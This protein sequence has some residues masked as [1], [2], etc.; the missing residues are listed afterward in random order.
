MP[1][2]APVKGSGEDFKRVPPGTH[3][4]VCR[5]I[6]D[7]GMQP[8]R[9]IYPQPK[10]EIYVGFEIPGERVSYN[11]DGKDVEGP[12]SIGRTYTLSMSEKANLRKDLQ[13]WRGK[14]F[15]DEEAE[16]FDIESVA[17]KACMLTVV[18]K[19]SGEKT[20]SNIVGVSGLPKGV[21]TPK[22]ENPVIVY[23]ED[24]TR[25]F[26]KLPKWLQEKVNGQLAAAPS[27]SRN[28]V[29]DEMADQYRGA[30]DDPFDSE[31]IPF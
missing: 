12:M 21:P 25:S 18:E 13:A 27:Q 23:T 2:R 7:L 14:N 5:L 10:H 31:S 20:Y 26:D 19:V 3:I 16:T 6:V 8:G 17:G 11:K 15:T 28:A 30:G 22:A 9:G 4:A 24:D 1:L 29:E